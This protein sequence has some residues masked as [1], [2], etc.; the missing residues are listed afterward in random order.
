M[1][2]S[3]S[4][5]RALME[6][7]YLRCHLKSIKLI[8]TLDLEKAQ[9]QLEGL[10]QINYKPGKYEILTLNNLALIYLK[11]NNATKA[12][13]ALERA[14]YKA[15]SSP[16]K[17]L[18]GTLINLSSV[19]SVLN[20]HNDSL[21]FALQAK[22]LLNFDQKL[23]VQVGFNLAIEYIH[24]SRTQ[25]AEKVLRQ[26]LTEINDSSDNTLSQAVYSVLSFLIS[27]KSKDLKQSKSTSEST[28]RKK[29]LKK[30]TSAGEFTR[31]AKVKKVEKE[32]KPLKRAESHNQISSRNNNLTRRKREKPCASNTSSTESIKNLSGQ[33]RSSLG[34]AKTIRKLLATDK[35]SKMTCKKNDGELGNRIHV[36][37][38]HLNS[39]E[40]KLNDFVESCRP[41]VTLTEDPDEQLDSQRVEKHLDYDGKT[42]G[43]EMTC[44][45][46]FAAV[47][48]Q[49]AWR[50][51][52]N[53][54]I[55]KRSLIKFKDNNPL[56]KQRGK[57]LKGL[58]KG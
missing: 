24:L 5:G 33:L 21:N 15:K 44:R 38:D 8:E 40:K 3:A 18:L 47:L 2:K 41:L 23:S 7:K 37:G 34:S 22:N 31:T 51:F 17:E 26:T 16:S 13:T 30:E 50:R 57:T 49:R 25:E 12:Y 58:R 1:D 52:R 32:Q 6:D 54:K 14:L 43:V 28:L 48:I 36:I 56:F 39:I 42:F 55:M 35:G 53:E 11:Q 45:E 29:V 46:N 4:P 19:A 27:R 9:K 10:Y 20:N